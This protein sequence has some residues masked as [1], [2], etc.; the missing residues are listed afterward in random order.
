MRQQNMLTTD[1]TFPGAMLM[2]MEMEVVFGTP[3]Q[4]CIGS[5]ICMVMSRL[6]RYQK[7]KCAHAPARIEYRGGKLCFRFKKEDLEAPI[8][9]RLEK[10]CFE[11]LEPFQLPRLLVRKLGVDYQ[12]IGKGY[13]PIIEHADDWVIVF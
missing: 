10:P 6:P 5:G 9:Q 4:N 1:Y 12:S 7:L 11:V 8:R 2:E 13:Y 3:S